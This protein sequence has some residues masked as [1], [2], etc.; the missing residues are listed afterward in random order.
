MIM[1][2]NALFRELA[3]AVDYALI[4]IIVDTPTCWLE[5]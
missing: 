5:S 1:E 2:S 4:Y 3:G